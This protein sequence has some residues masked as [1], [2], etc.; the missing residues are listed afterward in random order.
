M[1]ESWRL[2]EY[3][4]EDRAGVLRLSADHYREAELARDEYVDWLAADAPGGRPF[5]VV[6]ADGPAGDVVGFV[7]NVPLNVTIKGSTGRCYMSC[8]G[9]VHPD[10]RKYGLYVQISRRAIELMHDAD[11]KYGF[12]KPSALYSLQASGIKPVCQVPLLVRPLDIGRLTRARVPRRAE[13]VAMMLGWQ[14]VAHTVLRPAGVHGR[15]SN[16][17]VVAE[18][19]FDE[20]FDDLWQR[21]KD[22]YDLSVNRDR[23]FLTWRFGRSPFRGYVTLAARVGRDLAGYAVVRSAEVQGIPTGLIMDLLVEPGD[24]GMA[25]GRLLTAE[26][27]DRFRKAK[28]LLA[29]SLMLRHTQEYGILRQAGFVECP[30]RFS[31]QPFRLVAKP[32]REGTV[33]EAVVRPESWFVTMANHDA[34]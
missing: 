3:R 29:G 17:R 32:L 19:A 21:A 18:N 7:W 22:K 23:A 26:A 31:P 8:N 24:R 20:S 2:R 30:T 11:F 13:R 28:M 9:L 14:V 27:I 16:L 12:A 34:V 10:Y 1:S 33:A 4:D 5:A 6:A 15:H 25:A